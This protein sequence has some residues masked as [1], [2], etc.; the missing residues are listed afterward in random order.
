MIC[1]KCGSQ[2]Q[3]GN[4]CNKCGTDL[5]IFRRV[6]RISNSYYNDGLEKAN[7][8]NLSGAII[9]LKQ[10]L[11]FN[12]YNT[13]ERNLL[14]L[15]YYEMGETVDALS[16][17]VIS[18]N[19]SQKNNP[20]SRY[21]EDVH[22]NK[23]QL[24]SLNQTI[25]KFNQA[26]LYCK[27]GSRDLAIIQL[28]KVLSLNPKLIKAYQLLGL[29]Y[30]QENQLEKAKKTLKSAAKIDTDNTITLRY[31]QEV[32]RKMKEK[33]PNKKSK[34]EDSISYQSGNETIIM[35]K[36]FRESSTGSTLLYVIIGLIVGAAVTSFLFIPSVQNKAKEDAKSQL[37]NA[38]DTISTNGQ[39]ITD[40]ENEVKELQG[41]LDKAKK[42]NDDVQTQF[43]S[44][45]DLLTAYETYST[46][47]TLETGN[48]LESIDVSYLSDDAMERYESL[49]EAIH[50]DYFKELYR[51]GYSAYS[52]TNF[53]D[54][55]KYLGKVVEEEEDYEDGNAAYYLAQ[56]YN[57]NGQLDK[58]K[59]YYQYVIDNYPGT[60]RASTAKNYV[61]AEE[62]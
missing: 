53:P 14:G 35:P 3:E 47:D 31:M 7:V 1:Y 9:S 2:V 28:K 32:N 13:K 22:S 50:D 20:A 5:S 62:E 23:G 57:R 18:T 26:L 17:W 25:K 54:A 49:R 41:Q 30:I 8:R 21:L 39:T 33:S 24:E 43:D 60:Q 37:L 58:A 29:L 27:Q 40:L 15:V 34:S 51:Q 6:E 11:K 45:E 16:E 56:A 36:R 19:Y 42:K 38:N 46:G 10:S 44:Y 4:K 61:N 55:I 48:L 12:K 59:K 52:K